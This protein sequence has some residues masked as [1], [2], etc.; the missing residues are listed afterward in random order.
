MNKTVLFQEV[1]HSSKEGDDSV[2]K[3][4]NVDIWSSSLADLYLPTESTRGIVS[5]EKPR[6]QRGTL[7]QEMPKSQRGSLSKDKPKPQRSTLSEEKPKSQ[8][9][10][11]FVAEPV[12]P[13]KEKMIDGIFDVLKKDESDAT[14]RSS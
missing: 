11:S 4:D 13:N 5:K 3:S 2:K 6:S 10:Y 14:L 8:K 9:N 7:S 12:I 1:L